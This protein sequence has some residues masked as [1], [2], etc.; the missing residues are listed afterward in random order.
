MQY[1]GK[2]PCDILDISTKKESTTPA[3]RLSVIN[4]R[5]VDRA[6]PIYE[7]PNKPSNTNDDVFFDLIE[8]DKVAFGQ[9]FN[10]TIHIQNRSTEMRTVTAILSASSIYYTGV[11]ARRLGRA[12]RQLVL[13]PGQ[14]ETLQVR[15]SWDEYRDKIVDY[16]MIK[17]YALASVQETKQ[18]WSEEDDFQ[19]EKPKLDVQIRGTPQV[20]QDCFVTFSFLNP[21][22]VNL[23]ECEFT[24][25]G[26]GLVR[27][28]TI[29]YRDVKMG[30]MV[31]HVQ[32]FTPRQSGERKLVATFSSR[33][34]IDV[35]GS[36]PVHVR[37]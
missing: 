26:P 11:S 32:K 2:P 4:P 20:G 28:Q 15:V 27:P 19:L 12:D 5:G 10:V 36:R 3:E 21:L 29:K 1:P 30:E 6:Q 35:L 31:S 34:L 18:T 33:E 23:T 17:V 25:E 16:G 22:S 37:D 9:P 24:F 8:L 13:Q 14:R 7:F